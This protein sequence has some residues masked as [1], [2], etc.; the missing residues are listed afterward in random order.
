MTTAY[1]LSW[2]DGWPRTDVMRR[3]R[4]PS[5]GKITLSG[6]LAELQK[7]LRLLGA[8][9][10]VISSNCTLGAENPTDPGIA[11]YAHYQDIAICIP[12]DRWTSVP[13]NLRAIAKTI[14]AM[15]GMERWGA[16]HMIRAMFTGFKALPAPGPMQRPWRAVL[17]MPADGGRLSDARAYY[18]LKSK[19]VHPDNGGS[20]EA[21]VELNAA[22][23]Q[24][25]KELP[26]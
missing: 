11:V 13:G 18:I 4:W 15:R 19:Q 17:G 16:K 3:E 7:E 10:V 22:W 20:Q 6:A 26:A 2:P 14:E 25:Q 9:Q 1:P 21:M 5:Q 8:R 12:C 23:E 24:A